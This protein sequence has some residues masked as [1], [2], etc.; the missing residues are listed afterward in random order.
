MLNR[1]AI[2]GI[3]GAG[4]STLGRILA[5]KLTLP[6]YHAD[7][8]EWL[9]NWVEQKPEIVRQQNE[10]LIKKEKW[11]IEGWIDESKVN[12]LN[13]A[14]LVLDLD[15]SRWWCLGN[16]LRRMIRRQRRP[17][18]PEGCIDRF[19]WH[20]L[21]QVAHKRERPAVDGTIRIASINKYVRFT[22]PKQARNW[23]SNKSFEA[24]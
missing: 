2:V 12:R 20:F 16:N 1:I 15:Y 14:D 19:D 23:L 6:L 8:I 24:L 21:W 11:I 17:E 7:A 3:S 9:P 10:D 18:V 13:T 4:K 22:S 5:Q